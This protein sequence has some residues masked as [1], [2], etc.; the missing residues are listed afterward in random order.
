MRYT[1]ESETRRQTVEESVTAAFPWPQSK[2]GPSPSKY[3]GSALSHKGHD[4]NDDH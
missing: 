1:I 3:H 2:S 4:D